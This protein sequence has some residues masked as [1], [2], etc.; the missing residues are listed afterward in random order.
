MRSGSRWSIAVVAMLVSLSIALPVETQGPRPQPTQGDVQATI[1]EGIERRRSAYIPL[2]NDQPVT[3]GAAGTLETEPQ[4]NATPDDYGADLVLALR[5]LEQYWSEALPKLFERQYRPAPRLYQYVPSQRDNG[6]P[7]GKTVPGPRNAIYC[8]ANDTIQW[9]G[10]FLFGLYKEFGD[11]SPALVVA[12]E[13]GHA[14]QQRLG[15]ISNAAYSIQIELQADCLAGAWTRH[16]EV[17]HKILEPGDVDEGIRTLFEVR[18]RVG[19]PWFDPSAH[20]TGQ[21]RIQSFNNGYY[22][23][24]GARGCVN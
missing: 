7:C 1:A 11:F 4:P 16:A 23:Q 6:L 19:T 10:N 8:P 9:D 22:A 21:Q 15:L 13:W 20:G 14:V 18:D 24:S 12:H 3:R 2:P 5:S 17:V